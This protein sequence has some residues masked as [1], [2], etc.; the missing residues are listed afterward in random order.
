MYP[1]HRRLSYFIVYEGVLIS[2]DISTLHILQSCMRRLTWIFIFTVPC[3]VTPLITPNEMQQYAGVYLLQ[4]YSTCFGRL[5]HPSSGVHQTVT[6]ASG[7]AHIVRST[8]FRQRGLIR[9]NYSTCFECLSHPSSGV[10]QTVT[11][12][13]GIAHIVRSTIFRQ[14]G[15]K[16]TMAEDCWSDNMSCTRSCSYSLM[17]SWWWVR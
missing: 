16:A 1:M 12:A 8:T 2:A 15:L 11:A 6:A 3:I 14:R 9:Q 7:T 4:N 13:S 10:H 17:Y 5:S